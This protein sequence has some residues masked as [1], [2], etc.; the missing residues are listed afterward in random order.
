LTRIV[1]D[2]SVI[3]KWTVPGSSEADAGDALALLQDHL[4]GARRIF[5]PALLFYELA[6][7]LV[8]GKAKASLPVI[9]QELALVHALAL[10]VQLPSPGGDVAAAR[11]AR[12]TRI[13][14]YDA[15]YLALAA[16]LRC[17]LVTAD[18]KLIRSVKGRGEVRLLGASG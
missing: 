10:D 1:C 16:S 7:I 11:F 8:C 13:S 12:E 15:T 6:N 18:R 4:S 17:D 5:V 9:R 14:V 2:A 3:F